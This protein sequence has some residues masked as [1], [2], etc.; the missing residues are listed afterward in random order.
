MFFF[1][2]LKRQ[3]HWL[4]IFLHCHPSIYLPGHSSV[5]QSIQIASCSRLHTD[6]W[7]PWIVPGNGYMS[8]LLD[9]LILLDKTNW[10]W[11]MTSPAVS[12][13][14]SR[15]SSLLSRHQH[16]HSKWN[17]LISFK[18]EIGQCFKHSGTRMLSCTLVL[19]QLTPPVLIVQRSP[20]LE[21][22]HKKNVH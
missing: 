8:I 11:T 7:M 6:R 9:G 17:S 14:T 22:Y 1:S 13:T 3:R 18:E 4:V 16:S 10:L 19:K 12:L 15:I 20:K 5:W 21:D 2:V